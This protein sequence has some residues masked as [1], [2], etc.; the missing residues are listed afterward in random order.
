M[1]KFTLCVCCV[2]LWVTHEQTCRSEK[3]KTIEVK[4]AVINDQC[5][6]KDSR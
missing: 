4:K 6:W 1:F 5:E 2:Y 3:Q